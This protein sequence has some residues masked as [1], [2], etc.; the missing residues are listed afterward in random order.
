MWIKWATGAE[1]EEFE[2]LLA[3]DAFKAVKTM[4]TTWFEQGLEQ[5]LLAVP[6]DQKTVIE[7]IDVIDVMLTK[8]FIASALTA[9]D[10]GV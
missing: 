6:E 1:R 9:V 5:G 7:E 8:Q 3:D 10:A 4:G 2:R